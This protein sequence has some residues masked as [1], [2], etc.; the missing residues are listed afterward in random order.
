M[1]V[2]GKAREARVLDKVDCVFDFPPGASPLTHSSLLSTGSQFIPLFS[3]AD[4]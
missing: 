4:N 1:R 2:G 3:A